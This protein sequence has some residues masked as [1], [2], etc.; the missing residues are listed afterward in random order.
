MEFVAPDEATVFE[1]N[2]TSFFWTVALDDPKL[3]ALSN[4]TYWFN[5]DEPMWIQVPV[6][7]TPAPTTT[8][9]VSPTTLSP[10][11]RRDEAIQSVEEETDNVTPDD[12]S[13]GGS[14]LY[15]LGVGVSVALYLGIGLV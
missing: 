7:P 15:G 12:A 9:T 13:G 4:Q 3:K 14:R 1:G 6:A 10:T 11:S 5:T 2:V 8:P